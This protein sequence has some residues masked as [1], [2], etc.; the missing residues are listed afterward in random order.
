MDVLVDLRSV[1]ESHIA[2]HLL[3]ESASLNCTCTNVPNCLT[4]LS[5][6]RL[7]FLAQPW[8]ELVRTQ[9]S[10]KNEADG[11]KMEDV[12]LLELG[13][14]AGGRCSGDSCVVATGIGK[15]WLAARTA[16]YSIQG[17]LNQVIVVRHVA[18][19]GSANSPRGRSTWAI[20]GMALIALGILVAM[21]VWVPSP[22]S[23]S[24]A[25]CSRA[26]SR[27]SGRGGKE[28][29]F[30]SNP[31]DH[32]G[33]YDFTSF[34]WSITPEQV[35][36]LKNE[37]GEDAVI[38]KGNFGTVYEA[39]LDGA[40]PCAVKVLDSLAMTHSER[41]MGGGRWRCCRGAGRRTLCSSWALASNPITL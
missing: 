39:L 35:E 37:E 36:I 21:V 7:Q 24:S 2:L 33:M 10:E 22:F 30:G 29:P 14:E 9:G 26:S 12:P 38:G 4:A 5:R 11:Q 28:S 41:D 6:T 32:A 23:R 34:D 16:R 19:R 25:N 1:L 27:K 3:L 20:A 31:G 15:T 17:S 18:L 40:L 8:D 13:F